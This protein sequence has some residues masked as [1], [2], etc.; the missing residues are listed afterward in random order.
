MILSVEIGKICWTLLHCA[1]AVGNH[2]TDVQVKVLSSD[3]YISRGIVVTVH[4]GT[5]ATCG[6]VGVVYVY[7]LQLFAF[8][9]HLLKLL[10]VHLVSS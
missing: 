3:Y 10:L 1:T 6:H 5:L 8:G 4:V 9:T 2:T 7:A